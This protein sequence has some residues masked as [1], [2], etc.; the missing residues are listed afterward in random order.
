MKL[1][2]LFFILVLTSVALADSVK[3]FNKHLIEEVQKDLASENDQSFKSKEA[4][5][6]GPASVDKKTQQLP[7]KDDA[8]KIEK[9]YRQIGSQ[10]W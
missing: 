5:Q 1:T 3:D 10:R 8:E 2:I 6:R 7:V 4:V 9:N